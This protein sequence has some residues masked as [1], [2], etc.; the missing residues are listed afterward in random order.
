MYFGPQVQ[1]VLAIPKPVALAFSNS[2]EPIPEFI[3]GLGLIDTGA[4]STCIDNNA[5]QKLG[6]PVVDKAKMSSASHNS[7]DTNVY[8]V[9]IQIPAA[10][11]SLSVERALGANLAAQGI[12]ALIGRDV[13]RNMT[14]F[15]NGAMG[16]IT[17]AF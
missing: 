12:V 16:E 4:N 14:M 8:P 11:I 2:G 7:F 10:H 15:Y 13:L 1:I 3:P 9:E 5:A 17:L 6:L